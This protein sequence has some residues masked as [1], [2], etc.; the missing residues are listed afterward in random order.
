MSSKSIVDNEI[1]DIYCL[2][3]NPQKVPFEEVQNA[4]KV[5]R[6]CIEP[7]PC[8]VKSEPR[9][10]CAH[11]KSGNHTLCEHMFYDFELLFFVSK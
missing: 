9:L 4:A 10:I 11:W 8:Q 1:E 2:P 5:L 6:E 7:T 3:S